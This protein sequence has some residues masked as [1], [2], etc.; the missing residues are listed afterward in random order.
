M[1]LHTRWLAGIAVAAVLVPGGAAAAVSADQM[2]LA[3]T[4]LKLALA[5]MGVANAML[6]G[7]T[8]PASNAEAHL[9]P[10]DKLAGDEIAAITVGAGGGVSV[11]LKPVVGV[12]NGVLRLVPKIVTEQGKRGVAYTCYSPNIPDIANAAPECSYRPDSK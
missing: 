9:A 7:P 12:A 6:A 2:H 3:L 1:K 10:P 5:K 8:P 11:S 4:S